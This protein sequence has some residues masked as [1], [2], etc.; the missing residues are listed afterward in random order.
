M[1]VIS[2]FL[3]DGGRTKAK[4]SVSAYQ[5]KGEG[6]GFVVVREVQSNVM[7]FL[8]SNCVQIRAQDW[9]ALRAAIDKMLSEEQFSEGA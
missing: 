3:V 5:P 2:E 9:P 6:P 4:V 8:I 1:V 7:Q